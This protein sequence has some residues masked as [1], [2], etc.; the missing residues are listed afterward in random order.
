[1][2]VKEL[3][4]ALNKCEEQRCSAYKKDYGKFEDIAIS[5]AV[6]DNVTLKKLT[7]GLNIDSVQQYFNQLVIRAK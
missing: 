7:C 6:R 4:D 5:I 2:T 1:M 3:R